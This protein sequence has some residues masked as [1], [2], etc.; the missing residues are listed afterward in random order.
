MKEEEEGL[1]TNE[2]RKTSHIE[3]GERERE[4]SAAARSRVN[5]FSL[6][7]GVRERVVGSNFLFPSASTAG[8]IDRGERSA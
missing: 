6:S 4:R 5:A 7:I 3:S 2:D 1:N 8:E